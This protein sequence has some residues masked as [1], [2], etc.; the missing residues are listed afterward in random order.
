M[1]KSL[2]ATRDGLRPLLWGPRL[3]YLWL[4][5][6][7]YWEKYAPHHTNNGRISKLQHRR[8][9][10]WIYAYLI[11]LFCATC[12]SSYNEYHN[13]SHPDPGDTNASIVDHLFQLK[14][15]V[16]DKLGKPGM[17]KSQL[18]RVCCRE[19]EELHHWET[20]GQASAYYWES[21]WIV[22]YCAAFNYPPVVDKSVPRDLAVQKVVLRQIRDVRHVVIPSPGLYDL[23]RLAV[24]TAPFTTRADLVRYIYEWELASRIPEDPFIRRG[25][26]FGYTMKSVVDYFETQYRSH[27]SP[28]VSTQ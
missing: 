14:N 10:Q 4:T 2:S 18:K 16:N 27:G 7:W 24:P 8:L 1:R 23:N 20:K 21:F 13:E 6:S 17:P 22:I 12:R 9:C 28:V 19:H 5:T 26:L 25:S 3:W 11:L 15:K